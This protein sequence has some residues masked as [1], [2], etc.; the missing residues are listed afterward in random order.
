MSIIRRGRGDD[1]A[2]DGGGGIEFSAGEAADFLPPVVE[3][4]LVEITFVSR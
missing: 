3:A 4:N 1:P 2:V